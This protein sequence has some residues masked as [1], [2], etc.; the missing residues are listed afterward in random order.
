MRLETIAADYVL[1]QNQIAKI[2]LEDVDNSGHFRFSQA[3]IKDRIV[4]AIAPI[5][6]N[7][8]KHRHRAQIA[9]TLDPRITSAHIG[10]RFSR[11]TPPSR[12]G[13][14]ARISDVLVIGCNVGDGAVQRWLASDA[15]SVSGIEPAVMNRTWAITGPLLEARYGKRPNFRVGTAEA[16]PFADSSFDLITSEAVMEHVGDLAGAIA[17]ASRVLRPGGIMLHHFGPLYY[18]FGGDHCIASYGP[19]A[20][21]DHLL[22][23]QVEYR[24]RI[25]DM[26]FF[27]ALPQPGT[28]CNAW[29][30]WNRFSFARVA[31]YLQAF[32]LHSELVTVHATVLREALD[33]RTRHPAKWQQLLD[34]GVAEEDLLVSALSVVARKPL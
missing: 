33:F 30:V 13:D 12:R 26:D 5:A 21:F 4:D 2:P 31:D 19:D 8:L 22:L 18:S 23:A 3:R 25:M 24:R 7:V 1:T 6:R 17:E 32:G 34:A 27:G 16:I 11:V 9:A 20:G 29:A 15:K 14:G 10:Y 28:F